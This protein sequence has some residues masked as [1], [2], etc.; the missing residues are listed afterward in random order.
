MTELVLDGRRNIYIRLSGF[1][2]IYFFGVGALYPLLSV[3][4]KDKGLTGSQLGL[5]MSIGPIVSIITQPIWGMLCDR[6]GIQKK[7]LMVTLLSAGAISLIFP[8]MNSFWLFFI[9]T[10][11]LN[12][13]QSAVV[14]ITD[15]ISMNFVQKYGGQYGDI[16]LW[17]SLGFAIAVW[18]AGILSDH[19]Q[20]DIIFYLYAIS[21]FIASFL[22]RRMPN[23]HTTSFSVNVFKGIK[24]LLKVP[25][26]SLF[27]LGTFL[28]FG[29]MNANNTYFGIFYQ[30]IGGTKTGIGL[31]FLL[32]AGSEVPFM[33]WSGKLIN[34]FGLLPVMI[35]AA[36][37][38][39]ARWFFYSLRPSVPW[40]IA[41]TFV[42]GLS[43]GLFL[44]TA[45]QFVKQKADEEVQVSA[46]SLYGS[47][48]LGLGSFVSSMIGGWIYEQFG[49]LN[50]YVYMAFAS[51]L[52]VIVFLLI[53]GIEKKKK[54]IR[55]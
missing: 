31:A 32:A 19:L 28:L 10:G 49:I 42:Q 24:N 30:S 1:Y 47:F 53:W 4:F 18:V 38:T 21:L 50:T 37:V 25:S 16:R 33:R 51:F 5:V 23:E 54:S 7:V 45:V 8:I 46:M 13:F 41:T 20:A 11:I 35:F 14:P 40:V 17:G 26:F 12:I 43:I 29:T 22:T 36:F 2:Y 6:Y 27:L 55:E 52:S 34:K 3:Y 15:N 48:G 9:L 44:A 39:V